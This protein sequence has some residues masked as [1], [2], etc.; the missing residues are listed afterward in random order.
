MP[1][2]GATTVT[3]ETLEETLDTNNLGAVT[4]SVE[5][6]SL[7][8]VGLYVSG[9]SGS[10]TSHVITLEISPDDVE[11]FDTEHKVLGVGNVHDAK[12][13]CFYARAKVTAAEGSASLSKVQIIT[14]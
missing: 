2:S 14:T 1:I 10:H 6:G 4:D 3:K 11:W 8:V 12:C 13:A 9:V 5:I 7:S